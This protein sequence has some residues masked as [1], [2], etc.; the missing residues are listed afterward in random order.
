[1]EVARH[2]RPP[3]THSHTDAVSTQSSPPPSFEVKSMGTSCTGF[4]YFRTSTCHTQK[5][6]MKEKGGKS[7]FERSMFFLPMTG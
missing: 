3:S 4:D 2:P 5:M 7:I 1:M 6:F